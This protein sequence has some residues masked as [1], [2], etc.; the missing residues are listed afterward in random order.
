MN[1]K[2]EVKPLFWVGN[3][4]NDLRKFPE[5]VQDA[6][7][8]ALHQAQ[9]GEKHKDAKPL[10]GFGGASVLEVVEDYAGDTYRAVYTV[11]FAEAIYVVHAFQKKSRRG[12]ETPKPD[13]DLIQQR[14]KRAE[15]QHAENTKT[16]K[17]PQ[18]KNND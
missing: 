13:M 17:T 8:Y 12:S 7:G 11:K 3:S 2:K 1:Y 9:I 6:V 10:R 18:R 14:L 16:G 4:K 15:E 5:D